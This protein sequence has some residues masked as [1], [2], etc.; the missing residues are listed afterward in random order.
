ML[1][2]LIGLAALTFGVVVY[3]TSYKNFFYDE[4]DFVTAYRPRQATSILLPHNEHWST[5]PILLWKL[6]FAVFGLR[7][8]VPYEA[9]AAAAHVA[10]VLLLFAM[11]RRRSGELPA[12]AA[13]LILLVLGSGATNIVWAFQ[14][15]WTMSIAFGLAAMLL[16]DTGPVV[17][18]RRRIAGLS[19]LL[20]CS[21]MSSGVG[22]GFVV[23]VAV[24]LL[25]DRQQRRLLLGVAVPLAAYLAWFLAYGAGLPGTPGAPCA[26]CTTIVGTDV[27]SIGP[28]YLASVAVYVA[29]GLEASAA[30]LMGLTILGLPLV[31][32]QAILIGLAVLLAWHWYVQERVDSWEIGMFAGLVAQ[33]TLIGLVRVRFSLSG[34]SDPHY[35]Y[36]GVLYLLPLVANVVKH[37][38]WRWTWRPALAG[39]AAFAI[40]GNAWQLADQA[41]AQT[42]LM[43]V[44]NAELRTV[45]VFRGAPDM[46]LDS[47]L[48]ASI[49]PQLTA[50]NYL[51]AVDELGSPV[52][53]STPT[54]LQELPARVV[55]QEMLTLF[56]GALSVT[57]GSQLSESTPCHSIDSGA[58]SIVDLQ[59]PEGR[60][61][62]LQAS[63]GGDAWLSLG[64]LAPPPPQPL[65][66]VQLG[67][68]TP[69]FV[70]APN[71]GKALL[72][73]LR[74]TTASVGALNVCGVERIQ[75]QLG[76]S[77]LSA[78]AAGG[79]LDSGW[80]SVPDAG[81]FG[82]LSAKLPAG[83]VTDSFRNDLFGGPVE[84]PQGTYDVWYRVRVADS[85]RDKP[86]MMLGL[87]DYTAFTWIG[88]SNY[89]A[90][91]IGTNFAWV[92]AA[93]GVTPRAG[94]RV[95]FLAEFN[96]HR[97]ALGTDW[98]IDEAVV[99]PAGAAPPAAAPTANG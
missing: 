5:L 74:I 11:I 81:A 4:W 88:A 92:R 59:V 58:G 8:H 60:S 85:S 89:Q 43:K 68:A 63:N 2:S 64:Y 47:P 50:G 49:M 12:F 16:I 65:L 13:A 56:G 71:T 45:E 82:G 44:E 78:E 41:V 18:S 15:G 40:L 55:D 62:M 22:L 94:H 46:A 36:V 52:S 6:L 72:W 10:C 53:S 17:W 93:A 51:P 38:S 34:A 19:A 67:M 76:S 97:A 48:D 96:S 14:V 79:A 20:L 1:R 80:V 77:I 30:G 37:F 29:L 61:V 35:I 54:S 9:A 90:N 98:Y 66:Q 87:Y 91:Q 31:I 69:E 84:I 70:H 95:V 25:V 73:R 33:F 42:Q 75:V 57:A 28:G 24:H 99:V 32:A 83:T 23:A 7:T 86:E 27:H 39:A 21:L 3:L 26:A